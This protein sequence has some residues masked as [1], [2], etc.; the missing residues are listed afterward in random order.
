MQSEQRQ[1]SSGNQAAAIKQRQ[2]PA[3]VVK[4]SDAKEEKPWIRNAGFVPG[5][6]VKWPCFIPRVVNGYA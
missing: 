6:G 5:H 3:L 1:S 2:L 4:D